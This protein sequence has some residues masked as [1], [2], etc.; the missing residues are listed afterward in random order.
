MSIRGA[1]TPGGTTTFAERSVTSGKAVAGHFRS[2]RSGLHLSSIG[3]GTYLG[4][5]DAPTDSAVEQAVTISLQSGRVN[6]LD[7]AINYRH[8]RAERSVGR[9]LGRLVEQGSLDRRSVFVS[10]KVGYLAPDAES[11][12]PPHQWIEENLIRTKHLAPADI[13]EGSHAMSPSYLRDQF[14]RSRTNLGLETVDLLYLHNAADAQLPA[15]GRSEFFDR[16]RQAF[17]LLESWRRDGSLGTYGL[18]TWDALRVPRSDPRFLSLEEVLGVA[19]EVGGDDH[20]FRFVQFPFNLEMS[21]AAVVRN[22]PV[23]GERRSLL[24][25]AAALG[26]GCFTSV[27]LL[28]GQLATDGPMSGQLSAAQTALQFARSAPGALTALVGQKRAEHLSENLAVAGMSPFDETEWRS[29]LN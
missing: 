12:L 2:T 19:R 10:T 6:V 29:L 25:A 9:A 16:V 13:V 22:Q 23:K 28:Q 4:R 5:P 15:V 1:A 8:Q 27:P 21:E 26:I 11:P 14:E 17:E 20:G 24:E 18:A 3:L 7:T